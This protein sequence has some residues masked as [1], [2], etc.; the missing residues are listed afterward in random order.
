M[1]HKPMQGEVRSMEQLRKDYE[2]EKELAARLR[3]ASRQERRFLYSSVYDEYYERVSQA[4]QLIR[5]SSPELTAVLVSTQM[6]FLNRFLNKEATFLE[7]GAGDCALSIELSNHVKQVF[8]VD[9]SAN[10]SEGFTLPH[11]CKCIIS[12]GISFPVPKNSISVVYSNH[13]ME[14]LHPDDAIVQLQNIYNSLIGGGH[15]ICITPNR[16][17]GPHDISK[18]FDTVASGLHLKEYSVSEL[19]KLFKKIGF[20]RFDSYVGAKGYYIKVPITLQRLLEALIG[21]FPNNIRFL[22]ARTP[23]RGLLGIRLVGKK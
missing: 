3:N 21:R 9:A 6:R 15:Y 12:D 7:V 18:Y 2:I 10:I 11:N 4:P 23:L 22:I 13:L 19:V 1:I 20:S 14:H 8:A 17:S 16:L 5:K